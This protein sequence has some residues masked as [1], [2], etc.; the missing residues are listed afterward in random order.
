MA[1]SLTTFANDEIEA[2]KRTYLEILS[3]YGAPSERLD[4]CWQEVVSAY[5]DPRR[6][7]HTMEHLVNFSR[8]LDS[9]RDKLVDFEAAFLAMIY[10]D[11]VYFMPDGTNEEKSAAFGDRDLALL[12]YP[13]A[14]MAR[15]HDLIMATKTHAGGED[16][17]INYFVDADMAILGADDATY[18]R[19][20]ANIRKEYGDTP[21][22]DRGRQRVLRYF[23][24]MDRLFKTDWFYER[25]E[26]QARKNIAAEIDLLQA[27]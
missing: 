14:K 10:H 15:C 12:G 17:D 1:T 2:L 19:Y 11:V 26:V 24:D 22:F 21:Q 23:L 16:D 4:S 5:A 8:H 18:R 3:P 20:V 13:T 7:Y 25:F 6:H 27:D 9:C